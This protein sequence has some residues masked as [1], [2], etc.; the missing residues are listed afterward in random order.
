MAKVIN[1]FLSTQARG[2]FSGMTASIGVGGPT[3]RRKPLPV[4]RVRSTQTRS[5]SILGWLSR[6]WG[7]LTDA[8][9][10]AWKAYAVDHPSINKLGE[11][12][13]M[14]GINAYTSLNTVAIRLGG[15]TKYKTLPPSIDPPASINNFAASTGATNPGEIDLAWSHV[16]AGI[17]TDYNEIWLTGPFQ[18]E[19][20]VEVAEKIVYQA[21]VD[22]DVLVATI[23]DLLE[24]FW[25]WTAVRYTDVTGQKTN[26]HYS[27]ATPKLT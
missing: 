3:M 10:N 24:G 18:S 20:R 22:G 12:F 27:Q 21:E 25:Y 4:R 17:A 11:P 19:G 14:S 9:R 13:I 5:R 2:S 16:G 26:F 15:N 6:E 8:Q 7:D 1:P 23:A